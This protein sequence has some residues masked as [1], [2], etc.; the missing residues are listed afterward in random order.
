LSGPDASHM[1]I[2]SQ[3]SGKIVNIDRSGNV[4]SSLTI[5][6]DP[7]NPLSVPDQTDEG[8][9]MDEEGMLY[10]VNENGG[11][12]S[13]HPH[14]CVYEPQATADQAQT[15]VTLTHQTTSLP[16]NTNTTSRIKVASVE[17]TDA[18]GFGE[19]HLSATGPDASSFE[20]DSNGL[21]LK[22]GTTLDHTTKS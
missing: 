16:E 1:L 2:L 19:N 5:V 11:G 14:L 21:Y 7:G 18:D 15:G 12:D 13:N 3:E 10:V 8:V 4:S 22:A 17:V 9:T 20:V 6:S